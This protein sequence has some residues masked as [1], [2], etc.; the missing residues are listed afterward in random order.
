[1]LEID[2]VI[3]SENARAIWDKANEYIINNRFSPRAAVKKFNV[4]TIVTTEEIYASLN[5]INS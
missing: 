1:M 2:E 3:K 4:H 5:T